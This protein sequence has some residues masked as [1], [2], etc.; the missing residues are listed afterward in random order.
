MTEI[1][2]K[3]DWGKVPSFKDLE[4]RAL[5]PFNWEISFLFGAYFWE[6]EGVKPMEEQWEVGVDESE[7]R[8]ASGRKSSK[9]IIP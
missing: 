8:D 5:F 9:V 1:C 7:V 3:D 2:L 4:G 6:K